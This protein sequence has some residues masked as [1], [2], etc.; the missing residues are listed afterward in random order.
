MSLLGYFVF[1]YLLA[2]TLFSEGSKRR[3]RERMRK[4]YP[5]AYKSMCKT[6]GNDW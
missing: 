2:D 6:Y 4:K 3:E 1:C 5:A